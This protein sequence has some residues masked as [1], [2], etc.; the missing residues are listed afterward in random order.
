MQCNINTLKGKIMFISL[1][2]KFLEKISAYDYHH[3]IDKYIKLHN[4]GSTADVDLL[5]N[6]FIKKDGNTKWFY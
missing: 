2:H 5:V 3:K 4:P 1:M 6:E